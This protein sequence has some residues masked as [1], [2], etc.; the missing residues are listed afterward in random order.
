MKKLYFL[1]VVVLIAGIATSCKKPPKPCINC[2]SEGIIKTTYIVDTALGEAGTITVYPVLTPRNY[3][4]CD[5]FVYHNGAYMEPYRVYPK[6]F[7]CTSKAADDTARRYR[8]MP[9][10]QV[11]KQPCVCR[12]NPDKQ[13]NDNDGISRNDFL[14]I[15]NIEKFP[16]SVMYIRTP[17][18]TTKIRTYYNYDNQ[19]DVF[20]GIILRDKNTPVIEAKM[21]KSGVYE[22]ELRFYKDVQQLNPMGQTIKFKFAIVRSDKMPNVNC[23]KQARDQT[24]TKLLK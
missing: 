9:G 7:V 20:N 24:D 16:N 8:E 17:G 5:S 21:L 18:D 2:T 19:G 10:N 6:L 14:Y 11:A 4:F 3:D 13:F 1:A 15:E 23:L 12:E 22:A